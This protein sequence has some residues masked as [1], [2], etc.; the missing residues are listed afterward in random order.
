MRYFGSDYASDA[1]GFDTSAIGQGAI[2]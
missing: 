1:A 2:S